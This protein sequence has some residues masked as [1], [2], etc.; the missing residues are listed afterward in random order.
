[1]LCKAVGQHLKHTL[2][3]QRV[4]I[5]IDF[6]KLAIRAY[7]VH[8]THVVIVCMSYQNAV[9]TTERLIHDLLAEV[10]TTINEQSCLSCFHQGRTT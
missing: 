10:R 2:T 3:G 7:V 6:A 1:M 8:S 5:D 4:C 9:N